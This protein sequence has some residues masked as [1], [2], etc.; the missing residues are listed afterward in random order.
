MTSSQRISAALV[1]FCFLQS[2]LSCSSFTPT[3]ISTT[4][5]GPNNQLLHRSSQQLAS[6]ATTDDDGDA[7]FLDKVTKTYETFQKARSDGYDFK[8]STA[9]AIAGE[10]DTDAI[11]AEIE[12]QINSAP[13]VMFTW[14]ASP[15]CKKAIKYLD[16]AGAKYKVVRLDDPWES[17][18]PI[19]AELGKRVG[20]SS[21][22]CIFIGGEYVGGF[23]GGVGDESP[24]ILEMA[25]K[26]TLRE[27]LMGV[28]ALDD[29]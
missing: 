5:I 28:G 8:Q 14:E 24:G 22:P 13:C 7:S 16:V 21:V 15:A 20:R 9:I 17:G 29:A 23:D 2:F 6:T 11:K 10:Y 27:K 12:E 3:P 26:G 18:N 25:F 1:A 4:R 19:R